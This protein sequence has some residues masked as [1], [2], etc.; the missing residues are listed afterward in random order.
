MDDLVT[1]RLKEIR[2]TIG[3]LKF[4]TIMLDTITIFVLS[5]IFLILFGIN[6][7]F[8]IIPSLIYLILK[9]TLVLRVRDRKLIAVVGL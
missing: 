9:I 3:K 6:I 2:K 7:L 5:T 4:F 1:C 8:A